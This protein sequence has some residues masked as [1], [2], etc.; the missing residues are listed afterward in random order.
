MKGSIEFAGHT[1]RLCEP[2]GPLVHCRPRGL[3]F[4]YEQAVSLLGWNDPKKPLLNL[5]TDP[6]FLSVGQ[7]IAREVGDSTTEKRLRAYAEREFEPRVFGEENDRF[8]WWFGRKE[9]YPRG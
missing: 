5:A 6:R 3:T 4:L 1:P 7:L 9:P 8:G 2:Y